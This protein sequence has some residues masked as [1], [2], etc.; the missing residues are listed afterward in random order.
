[1][2]FSDIE[3]KLQS[4][5][6][7]GHKFV[8]SARNPTWDGVNLESVDE[9]DWADLPYE[10]GLSLVKWI[11]EDRLQLLE[12]D[13]DFKLDLLKTSKRFNLLGL[14]AL[15][16]RALV[17]SVNVRNC[18]KF[19]TTAEEIGASGLQGHCSQLISTHWVSLIS[20]IFPDFF[21]TS[22]VK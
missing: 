3:I 16:E 14:M 1:M 8:L 2:F 4:E 21:P 22:H 18:I 11:Y 5:T 7:Y 20:Y 15:C 13:S 10:V 9:L 6:L 12:R 19:Y 17:A